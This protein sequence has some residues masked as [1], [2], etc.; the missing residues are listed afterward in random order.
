MRWLAGALVSILAAPAAHA[1]YCGDR[2]AQTV[3]FCKIKNSSR[4]VTVCRHEDNSFHYAY[5]KPGRAPELELRH[6]KERVVY[7]PWPGV[8]DSFWATLRFRNGAYGYTVAYSMPKERP[9]DIW[10]GLTVTKGETVLAD[11]ECVA[12]TLVTRLDELEGLF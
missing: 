9:E 6:P 1:D 7:E 2:E 4:Q 5:G 8:S 12:R 3:F 11:K 10:G